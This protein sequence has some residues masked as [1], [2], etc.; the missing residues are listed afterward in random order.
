MPRGP[1]GASHVVSGKSGILSSCEGPPS[2]PLE[3]VQVTRASSRVEVGNSGFL[4]SSDRDLGVPME[5]PQGSQTS[6]RIGPGNSTFLSR[7]KRGVRRPVKLRSGSEAISR[8]TKGLSGLPSCRELI[9]WVTFQSSQ[10]NEALSQVDGDIRVFSNSG[11]THGVPLEFRGET[12]LLLRCDRNI[13]I[14]L[15]TEQ[16]NGPSSRV[17][18]GKPGLFLSCGG[19]LGVPLEWR[20]V[21]WGTF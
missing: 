15:Q 4:S 12:G 9:L 1:E 5:I 16:G 13:R 8:G 7:W 14:P 20:Q 21:C 10:G 6:S 3:L 2:I 17:E 19:K 11:T 18:E